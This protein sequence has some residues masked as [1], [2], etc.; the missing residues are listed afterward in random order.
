MIFENNTLIN[1]GKFYS[2]IITITGSILGIIFLIAGINSF[3]NRSYDNKDNIQNDNVH[4]NK[5][6]VKGIGL[7]VIGLI[8]IIFSWFYTWL[9]FRSN[10]YATSASYNGVF[11]LFS[12]N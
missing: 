10:K 5:K 3:K 2:V 9:S 6:Y 12:K 7:L 1:F 4:T 11:N 8:V